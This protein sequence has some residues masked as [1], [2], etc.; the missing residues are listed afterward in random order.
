MCARQR[1]RVLIVEDD[2]GVRQGLERGL[3]RG[4]FD[5]VAVAAASEA[6]DIDDHDIALVDLGLP[7]SDGLD[8]CRQ[9]RARHRARP[10][11]VVTGRQ[12]ELDVVDAFDAGADGLKMFPAELLTPPVLKAWRAWVET[13]PDEV[14]SL[15]RLL[16][17]PPIPEIP[18][19]GLVNSARYTVRFAR[20]RWQ[21]RGAIKTLGFD[22]RQVLA[23]VGWDV[24]AH[25]Q[26][27]RA[28]V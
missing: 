23:A 26:I 20:A 4:G 22:R 14:T 3:G 17:L 19:P 8:L 25:G 7:D 27:G 1:P 15:G 21:R 16:H 18:E 13:V 2:A 10:I 9:L 6:L 5:T 28:H 12:D 11:I 24:E